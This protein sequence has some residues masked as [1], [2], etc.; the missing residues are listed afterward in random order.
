MMMCWL[1]LEGKFVSKDMSA[2]VE[3]ARFAAGF[4][5]PDGDAARTWLREMSRRMGK[6]LL[7]DDESEEEEAQAAW[8]AEAAIEEERIRQA[9]GGQEDVEII[10]DKDAL[11]KANDSK[12]T[13]NNKKN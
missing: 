5:G 2:A 13:N 3:Y 7:E 8:M 4:E 9:G 6:S 10:E 12:E 11:Q 1:H